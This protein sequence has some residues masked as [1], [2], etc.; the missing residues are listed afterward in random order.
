M[1]IKELE[2]TVMKV[3]R[4]NNEKKKDLKIVSE[5][6]SYLQ[7]RVNY[8]EE[9]N[10]R[11][12]NKN[13]NKEEIKDLKILGTE[14]MEA[15]QSP[16][17]QKNEHLGLEMIS[18]GQ[19]NPN[20]NSIVNSFEKN[21]ST[22]QQGKTST[23]YSESNNSSQHTLD[24]PKIND[25]VRK[26]KEGF[27]LKGLQIAIPE[28]GEEETNDLPQI[29][30]LKEKG[31]TSKRKIR[32]QIKP[33]SFVLEEEADKMVK[34]WRGKRGI[35]IIIPDEEPVFKVKSTKVNKKIYFDNENVLSFS[36][37]TEDHRESHN[38]HKAEPKDTLFEK[39]KTA[40]T[41]VFI[42]G[43][44]RGQQQFAKRSNKDIRNRRKKTKLKGKAKGKSYRNQKMFSTSNLGGNI[45]EVPKIF[46][47]HKRLKEMK[48]AR[49]FVGSM[50]R[51]DRILM[52]NKRDKLP[53]FSNKK[54]DKG[55]VLHRLKS[56]TKNKLHRQN[57]AKELKEPLRKA[58]ILS[59]KRNQRR[60]NNVRGGYALNIQSSHNVER[61]ERNYAR[62]Y[63][64]MVSI[65]GQLD[66]PRMEMMPNEISS[67]ESEQNEY[68]TGSTRKGKHVERVKTDPVFH[69][70][71]EEYFHSK[72]SP[73][74]SFKDSDELK[75]ACS[76]SVSGI[77]SEKK[78]NLKNKNSESASVIQM[79]E[80]EKVFVIPQ[81]VR[82]RGNDSRTGYKISKQMS[83]KLNNQEPE[84]YFTK[85]GFSDRPCKS[86]TKKIDWRDRLLRHDPYIVKKNNLHRQNRTS[87][88]LPTSNHFPVKKYSEN[89]FGEK[90]DYMKGPK[91]ESER[92]F[93]GVKDSRNSKL[94]KTGYSNRAQGKIV[95]L[96]HSVKSGNKNYQKTGA[97]A[98][99]GM[100]GIKLVG[101]KNHFMLKK[102]C[103]YNEEPVIGVKNKYVAR[104][105]YTGVLTKS[106]K[107]LQLKFSEKE[108]K[109]KKGSLYLNN[110][111]KAKG[112]QRKIFKKNRKR[113]TNHET[114]IINIVNNITM[115]PIIRKPGRSKIESHDLRLNCEQPH[116]MKKR[117]LEMQWEGP[118]NN[119][120]E[121]KPEGMNVQENHYYSCKSINKEGESKI[122]NNPNREIV[123]MK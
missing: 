122:T 11:F 44:E 49:N 74:E 20:N 96:R 86:P 87:Q 7:R 112:I 109:R 73:S 88:I 27:R 14:M 21:Q 16:I 1:K 37:K 90:R 113:N 30:H 62:N 51:E 59:N 65:E 53:N 120:F 72:Q 60:S 123:M 61:H 100:T 70:A 8:L 78:A 54:P 68:Y 116:M 83:R 111:S 43:N 17:R 32:V 69:I 6:R 84:V 75:N 39:K 77:R 121:G 34:G 97:Y 42:E 46:T 18:I 66:S 13:I 79:K 52:F 115:D 35:N 38:I 118:M 19:Y 114:Q 91:L 23:L 99:N 50:K 57:I 85:D 110:E 47:S 12:Q 10:R 108:L 36:K 24:P 31:S 94:N 89:R 33:K 76:I 95:S 9:E 119:T 81:P 3:N 45:S 101:Q 103:K 29:S 92:Y 64:K 41:H 104:S 102:G 105:K 25:R 71:D 58:Q 40:Q 55:S 5:M 67:R 28:E 22:N 63:Q 80:F 107:K 56:K 93:R 82:K 106:G 48:M 26:K 4:E 117:D 2:E 15:F 98:I